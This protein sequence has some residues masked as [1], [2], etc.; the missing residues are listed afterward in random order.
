MARV[1][2]TNLL[3]VIA[4]ASPDDLDALAAVDGVEPWRLR[5]YGEDIVRVVQSAS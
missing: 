2:T 4:R 1:A 3:T 5:E